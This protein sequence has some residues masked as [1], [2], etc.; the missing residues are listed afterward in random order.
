MDLSKEYIFNNL[1][2]GNLILAK[3][4]PDTSEIEEGH[5]IGP[6]LVLG[7]KGDYLVCLYGTSKSFNSLIKL[8]KNSYTLSKDTYIKSS[9]QL[10]SFE[11][12]IS[13]MYQLKDREIRNLFK[14]IYLKELEDKFKPYIDIEKQVLEVG[15]IIEANKGKYL[16]IKVTDTSYI[17]IK[18]NYN[19]ASGGY[20]FNYKNKISLSKDF[21]YKRI[22]F[23][24]DEEIRKY[25]DK[26]PEFSN[27]PLKIGNLIVSRKLLYYLYCEIGAK[28]LSFSVSR[29]RTP[30][31]E[32]IIIDGKKY[33]AKFNSRREFFKSCSDVRLVA[34]ATK[35]ENDEINKKRR[36]V[37]SRTFY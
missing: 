4:A 37:K 30:L 25:S 32:E 21:D 23:L 35:E 6:F 16:I 24:S 14:S 8:S 11:D 1:T 29:K 20:K 19:K 33:Y 18:A 28:K 34:T 17:A 36:R 13:L 26:I 22:G 31:S 7:R 5:K 9:I 12:F 15:D 2:L 10:I 27:S 3:R